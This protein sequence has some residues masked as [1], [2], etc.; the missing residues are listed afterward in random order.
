MQIILHDFN[1][2]SYVPDKENKGVD[3]IV[4]KFLWTE[5]AFTGKYQ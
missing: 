1:N 5:N 2:I 3:F 4:R